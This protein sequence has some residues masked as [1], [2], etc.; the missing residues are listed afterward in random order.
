ML[1]PRNIYVALE[2]SIKL[3]DVFGSIGQLTGSL[4]KKR[5]VR[6]LKYQRY[7]VLEGM[8]TTKDV[9]EILLVLCE[10]F[11]NIN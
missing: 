2:Y 1:D 5:N 7:T 8:S 9:K 6:A 11:S 10:Y 3:N 4:S